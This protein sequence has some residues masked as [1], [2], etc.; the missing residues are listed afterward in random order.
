MPDKKYSLKFKMSDGNTKTVEFTV[1]QGETGKT[2]YV[3]AK[4]AG[5]TGTEEQFA[6]KLAQ[7]LPTKLP[8]PNALII[9]GQ[10]YD[11][12]ELVEVNI[13]GGAT[14]SVLSDNLFDKSTAVLGKGF[15]HSSSGVQFV[16]SPDNYYAYVELRGAGTYRT[17]V[18]VEYLSESYAKRVPLLKADKAWIQNI[19]GT[20]SDTGDRKVWDLEFTVTQDMIDAGAV[21][22]PL[23]ISKNH[24]DTVMMVKDRDYPTEYIPYGY[25]EVEVD[26]D[27][28]GLQTNVLYEKTAVFLG[29]SICAGDIEGSEYDGYGWAGLIGEANGMAWKNYGRNGG[30]ITPIESV[31]AQSRDLGSQVNLAL[32]DYPNA[33]YVIFEGG[34]NDAYQLKEAGLGVIS[35]DFA[36]FDTSTF[37]GAMESLIFKILTAFPK[38]QVGYIV[39]QK[40][41]NPPYTTANIQRKYFDRAVEICL[42]WGIPVIDLWNG[43][44]LNPALTYHAENFYTD[45]QHLTLAGYQRISPMIEAWMRNLTMPGAVSGGG[46]SSAPSDWNAEE[47][48]PGHVLNRT[49][50]E[51]YETVL[52][53]TALVADEDGVMMVE[54]DAI[55]NGGDIVTV[56]W[57]GVPYACEAFDIDT[58][59]GD[60]TTAAALGNMVASGGENTGEPFFIGCYPGIY[61][62]LDFTGS[63]EAT[64]K[65]DKK[66]AEKLPKRFY[67]YGNFY[68]DFYED[69]ETYIT[70]VKA[71]PVSK[72][73]ENGMSVCARFHYLENSTS[74]Y[75]V[76]IIPLSHYYETFLADGR[77][78]FVLSSFSG[79]GPYGDSEY[80]KVTLNEISED[81][82]ENAVYVIAND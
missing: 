65:I 39:A 20:I 42:K 38:A 64:L 60:G 53:E 71:G 33:D 9:N 11:G 45:K 4:E 10:I 55:I 54:T 61:I 1:P 50:Y 47:G 82:I 37:S 74:M 21:Y 81:N 40:M 25:I 62:A 59:A 30:T 70:D 63:T 79:I 76:K 15:Y 68:V 27:T 5:Y 17:K 12:S 26:T 78:F 3:Y 73:I 18:N 72:A 41:G 19:T 43:S 6:A 56:Y 49:H 35:D 52:P 29:D 7:E 16:D 48:E 66:I 22:Y 23:T 13:S 80:Y 2:A 57:N 77:R 67:D 36:N 14:E 31:V 28:A 58:G 44:F 8:N 51:Y 69:G 46:G 75:A 34:T 32:A 24:I